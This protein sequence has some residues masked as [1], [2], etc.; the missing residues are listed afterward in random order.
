[1]SQ[2]ASADH[3][4]TQFGSSASLLLGAG[5]SNPPSGTEA[6]GAGA[7]HHAA[8]PAPS[9]QHAPGLG[10]VTQQVHDLLIQEVQSFYQYELAPRARTVED[11]VSALQ[12]QA[13]LLTNK[14]TAEKDDVHRELNRLSGLVMA[15]QAHV[16]EVLS[17]VGGGGLQ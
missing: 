5:N 10:Y 15:F 17:M 1:M 7:D 9:S 13:E 4:G 2:A 8:D 14:A 11:D 6:P 16:A 3:A 12:Y